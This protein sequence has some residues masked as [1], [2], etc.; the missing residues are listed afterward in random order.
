[1]RAK[2]VLLA[3]ALA[4]LASSGAVEARSRAPAEGRPAAAS[5]PGPAG[6]DAVR[7]IDGTGEIVLASERRVVLADIRLTPLPDPRDPAR[8][9]GFAWLGTLA[10]RPVSVLAVGA[11]DRWGREAAVVALREG[12]ARID[13]AELLVAEGLAVVDA[14]E[15]DVLC[16]PDLLTL[17]AEARARRRGLWAGE[18]ALVPADRV[19]LLRERNGRFAVVEGRVVSVGERRD[20]TYLNFG[21]DFSRDFAAVVP[22]RTWVAL[23]ASGISAQSLRGRTVRLRGIVEIRRAPVIE[24]AAPGLLERPAAGRATP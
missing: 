24:L 16:R 12:E 7:R 6:D 1:M 19:D 22:R 15:R 23:K 11:P 10:D 8:P 14:G 4:G 21:R 17:E 3:A 18:T 5:C 9:D 20:R 2:Q 13:L